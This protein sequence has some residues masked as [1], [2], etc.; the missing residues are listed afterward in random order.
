VTIDW[1]F[2]ADLEGRTFSGYV[3]DPSS[4]HSGV[5]VG[6]GFDLGQIK[7][8]ALAKMV[9]D[10][11]LFAKLL[12][13]AGMRGKAAVDF[14][15]KHPL[16]LTKQQVD[17][18]F[19]ATQVDALLTLRSLYGPRWNLFPNPAQ[20][21]IASVYYQYGDLAKHT[22]RFYEL[23]LAQDWPGVIRELRNFDDDYSTRRNR[24]ADYLEESINRIV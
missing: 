4:S 24:E 1:G 8:D 23:T 3:P 21:V 10:P 12:P 17:D 16:L 13:Y 2:I 5:T 14:L 18:L 15:G 11:A 22:P 20:T 9:V 19:E 7:P 6:V